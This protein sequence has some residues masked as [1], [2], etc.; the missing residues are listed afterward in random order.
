MFSKAYAPDKI[1]L[2]EKVGKL[3]TDQVSMFYFFY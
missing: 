1:A 2:T 3:Y